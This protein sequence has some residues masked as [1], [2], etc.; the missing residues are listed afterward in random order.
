MTDYKTGIIESHKSGFGSSDAKNIIALTT[1]GVPNVGLQKRIHA[2]KHGI[3]KEQ[4]STAAMRQGDAI[5]Q[6]IYEMLR[7]ANEDENTNIESN[8]LWVMPVEYPFSVFCHPDQVVITEDEILIL[9]NKASIKPIEYWKQEALYQVAW[10]YMCAKAI[11]PDKNIRVRL[12]HYDTTDY[13]QF[14]ASKIN[15]FEFDVS[16][17]IQFSILFNDSFEYLSQNWETFEYL[18]GGELDLTVVDSNHPLQ[19]Q[20]KELEKAV[21]AEKKAKEEIAN[22]REQ[23]T[24]QMLNAGIKKIQSENMTVTLVNETVESRLD[25]KRLKLEQPE[26]AERYTKASI[27]KAFI[28][29]K[30]KE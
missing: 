21:L 1:N 24:E 15:Y 4:I 26:I 12:V 22:F 30:V 7:N 14:D 19:I 25:S 28:K 23:L 18:E 5:E 9:E 2:I 17:L 16:Y 3:E 8:P 20:I 6:Q 29:M 11:Y 10:Q 27:K 13:V